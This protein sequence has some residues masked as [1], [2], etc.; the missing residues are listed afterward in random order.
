[1]PLLRRVLVDQAEYEARK[2]RLK[3]RKKRAG[4]ALTRARGAP[5]PVYARA[6]SRY[7]QAKDELEAFFREHCGPRPSR[8]ERRK[9]KLRA[10]GIKPVWDD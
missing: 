9:A 5:Q 8:A 10:R 3:D 4:D 6:V 1:M 7:I 2:A